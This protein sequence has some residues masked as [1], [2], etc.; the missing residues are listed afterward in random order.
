ML[1]SA[2]DD[3]LPTQAAATS[4]RGTQLS[5]STSRPNIGSAERKD[6]P[7]T[8]KSGP[9]PPSPHRAFSAPSHVFPLG[10]SNSS[11]S[12]QSLSGI[13]RSAGYRENNASFARRRGGER[14]G[15]LSPVSPTGLARHKKDNMRRRH[16]HE[17]KVNVYTECGRHGD[18]WLFGSFSVSDMVKRLLERDNK[19][20]EHT[21]GKLQGDEDQ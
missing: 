19:G 3:K 1:S 21:H 4:Q 20:S 11:N 17:P 2:I 16:S 6:S 9:L 12:E 13:P 15:E 14:T 18:D 7:S 8:F 5:I 10:D